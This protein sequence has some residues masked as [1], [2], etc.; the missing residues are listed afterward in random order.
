MTLFN[1][2]PSARTTDATVE[3]YERHLIEL[4]ATAA[5]RAI[6]RLIGTCTFLPSI[7]EVRAACLDLSNGPRRTGVEAFTIATSAVE[8]IGFYRLPRFKDKLIS[9]TIRMWGT[10]EEFCLRDR[11]D[12]AGRARF[13]EMYDTLSKRGRA[14]EQSG[15]PLPAVK[16][17]ERIR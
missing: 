11:D 14:D 1:A 5:G 17:P 9:E 10:W 7:A 13:I 2:F 8:H 3:A 12:P 15:V 4:D 16:A 6:Q